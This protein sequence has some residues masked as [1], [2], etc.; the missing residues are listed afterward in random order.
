MKRT[1]T[2]VE[3]STACDSKTGLSKRLSAL[4]P[5]G[6]LDSSTSAINPVNSHASLR[7]VWGSGVE[8]WDAVSEIP[9]NERVDVDL[10][11]CLTNG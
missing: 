10:G 7:Q 1:T 8:H 4:S 6:S 2:N 11:D 5:S 3:Q 9:Q